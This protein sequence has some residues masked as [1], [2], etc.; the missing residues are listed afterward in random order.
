M[1]WY[2]LSFFTVII[3]FILLITIYYVQKESQYF[4]EHKKRGVV[5]IVGY[6]R[7]DRISLTE[8]TWDFSVRFVN[9]EEIENNKVF[10]CLTE[11]LNSKDYPIGT[12]INV[13]Y[14]K[15]GYAVHIEMEEHPPKRNLK[16]REVVKT[17]GICFFTISIL[18]LAI[19]IFT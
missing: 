14:A 13:W 4:D 8:A 7:K 17:I 18:F 11:G 12:K 15:K 10:L 5:E 16:L 1:V 2:I 19:G 9:N 6:D 3:A